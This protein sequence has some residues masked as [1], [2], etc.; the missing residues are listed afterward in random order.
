MFMD[1]L[2]RRIAEK[3]SRVCLGLDP[4]FQG[5]ASIPRFLLDAAG[6]SRPEAIFEFNSRILEAVHDVVPVVKPQ[7]AFYMAHDAMDAL[8]RTIKKAKGLGLL[9]ILDGKFND[10]G[11]TSEAYATAAF[12]VLGAD[13]ATVNGYLG[14]DCVEPFLKRPGK[15]AFVLAKTSNK[16]SGEFQDLFSMPLADLPAGRPTALVGDAALERNYVRMVKLVAAWN[17]QFK[18]P[19]TATYGKAGVVVGATYPEQL[20]EVRALLPGAFILV[21]GY[22]AQGATAAD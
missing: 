11:S 17:E 4:A 12:D 18:D 9:V 10:I 15:G 8:K 19:G 20:R 14:T 3:G 16:S 6:G 13:A 7:L 22:G 2:A 5:Q 1:E 21:P